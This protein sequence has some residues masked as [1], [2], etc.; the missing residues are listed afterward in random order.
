MTLENQLADLARDLEREVNEARKLGDVRA[1]LEAANAA[2]DRLEA[3]VGTE[4]RV[5]NEGQNLTLNVAQRIGYNVAADVWP[6]WE[7]D[8]PTRSDTE[9]QA[10]QTLARRS[11]VLVDRLALGALNRGTA[12]WLIGAFDL[13]RGR[14]KEAFAAFDTAAGFY[15]NAPAMKLMSEGYMA[16][17]T[18]LLGSTGETPEFASVIA[19]LGALGSE[20]AKEFRHQLQV[21]RQVFNGI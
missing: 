20:E 13:A 14:R 9:L 4:Q 7:I 3:A 10:A 5:L 11:S 8:T 19:G 21:A 12:I 16:I 6:G 18:E 17:A 15:A 1:L 2:I